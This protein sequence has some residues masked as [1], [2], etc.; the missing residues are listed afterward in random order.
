MNS[1]EPIPI[2]LPL[3]RLSAHPTYQSFSRPLTP[4]EAQDLRTSI[5]TAGCILQPIIVE[6]VQAKSTYV[7]IDGYNRWQNAKALGFEDVPCVQVSTE[8]QRL[9][10]LT[11]N[12]TRRQLTTEERKDLLAKGRT[13]FTH[14]AKNLIPELRPLYQSGDLARILGA[15]NVLFLTNASQEKQKSL[16]LKIQHAFGTLLPSDKDTEA[17]ERIASLSAQIT[18]MQSATEQLESDLAAAEQDKTLLQNKLDTM[19]SSIETL[20]D[21]KAGQVK[22]GL[23]EQI[24]TLNHRISVLTENH[25]DAC[26]KAKVLEEQ[27][28]TAESE[29]KAAQIYARTAESKAHTAQ[30]RLANPQIMISNF[31]S[32]HKLLEAIKA[33]IIAAKPLAPEDTTLMQDQIG[34]IHTFLTDLEQ[35]INTTT[36]AL[37]PFPRHL[38]QHTSA[39]AQ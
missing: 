12:A 29:A 18:S 1:T 26:R 11:A 20:A 9:E 8:Q 6:Y 21:K 3:T 25:S 7:V 31:E 32:I 24:R 39:Q 15:S 23:E 19:T 2:R 16:Y 14:S 33:Q 34:C 5:A 10:A 13:A 4:S 38:K 22:K 27:L 37:I 28:R 35:T 17:T 30:Q 36:G